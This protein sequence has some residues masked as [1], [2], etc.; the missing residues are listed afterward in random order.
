MALRLA[1]LISISESQADKLQLAL[2]DIAPAQLEQEHP[3]EVIADCS[4]L[5]W[6][7]QV[8][9]H[10]LLERFGSI[11]GILAADAGEL[12][13]EKRI[14]IEGVGEILADQIVTFFKQSHNLKVIEQL[15]DAEVTWESAASPAEQSLVGLTFVLTGTLSRPR[16]EI[17]EQLQALG[18]KV[19]GSVSKKTDYL[20]AGTDAG[21]KLEK[22]ESLGV[23]VLDEQGLE[24]LL[25]QAP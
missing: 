9:W 24:S 18:A 17:K 16:Q 1:D 5:K 4:G 20:V 23:T 11:D 7:S 12:V 15:K 2:Q 10:L 13:N 14:S 6:F 25:T 19:T 22:A 8:H 3:Y 21:S